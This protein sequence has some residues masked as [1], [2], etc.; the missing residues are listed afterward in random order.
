MLTDMRVMM[1]SKE[2]ISV[3]ARVSTEDQS[4]KRQNQLNT[5]Y[6]EKEC[7]V[8]PGK[9]QFYR[10]KSTGTNTSRSGYRDMIQDAENGDLD[11]LVVK[12][13]SRLARSL[14]DLERTVNRLN[15]PGVEIHICDERMVFRPDEDDHF[16]QLQMQLLG[17][18]AEFEAKIRQQATREGIAARQANDE[19]H[20]GPAPLGF[21]KEDGRLIEAD[22]YER[23]CAVLDMVAKDELSKR[24]A[25]A[26]LDTSRATVR[27]AIDERGDLY[28][29]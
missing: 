4:L 22:N 18:F 15:E 11:A 29:L 26:E 12:D 8:H 2:Q 17:A 27:R 10:D 19:Y 20:H 21:S 25:A 16:Q 9:I 6:A 1:M 24:K 7:D 5:E 23:V 28:G 14:Q 13:L 3:Y